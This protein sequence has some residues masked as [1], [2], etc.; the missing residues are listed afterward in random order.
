[1]SMKSRLFAMLIMTTSA[2][3]ADNL[4]Y[5]DQVGAGADID[6]TQDGDSNIIAGSS[7]GSTAMKI[8]GDNSSVSID[9]VGDTNK[10]IGNFIG[11]TETDINIDGDTN[12]VNIDIDP[13]DVY[14]GQNSNITI[15]LDGNN[16]TV[17][18]DVATEDSATGFTALWTILGDYFNADVDVDAN[19]VSITLDLDS[20]NTDFTYDGDGYDGHEVDITGT[21]NYWDITVEQQSTLQKDSVTIEYSGS[22]DATTGDATICVS[23]SDS[24]TAV[25]CQ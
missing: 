18:L 25:G 23:Q 1:M 17:D 2:Y 13:D 4:I 8:E 10:V 16:A 7:D 21:G 5:I 24:G 22:G 20:D 6:L 3:A 9:T 15:D 11:T 12:T 19:D 14:G